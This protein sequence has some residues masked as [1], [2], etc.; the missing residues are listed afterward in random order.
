VSVTGIHHGRR[1]WWRVVIAVI[2]RWKS[3][4]SAR[5]DR[6]RRNK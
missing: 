2:G 1:R 5:L 6:Q 3:L 4:G